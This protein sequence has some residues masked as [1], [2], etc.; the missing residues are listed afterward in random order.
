MTSYNFKRRAGT[1]ATDPYFILQHCG[2]PSRIQIQ[3]STGWGGAYAV[4]VD[5]LD[6]VSEPHLFWVAESIPSFAAAA[7]LAIEHFVATP[8]ARVRG[9]ATETNTCLP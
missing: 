9:S 2:E 5:Y 6:D 8:S 3:D 4:S 1:E 7:R